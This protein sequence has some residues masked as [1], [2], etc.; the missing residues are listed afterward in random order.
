MVRAILILMILILA[1]LS[2]I[3][4][5]YI[6]RKP[7]TLKYTEYEFT[8]CYNDGAIYCLYYQDVVYLNALMSSDSMRCRH[9]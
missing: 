9:E 4:A 6:N 2:Y 3:G 1:I 5:L 8:K 7:I